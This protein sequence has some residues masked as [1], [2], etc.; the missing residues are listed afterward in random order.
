MYVSI[1]LETTGLKKTCQILEIGAVSSDLLSTFHCYVD[2]GTVKGEPYA[3]SIHS[4]ILRRIATKE[5]GYVYLKPEEVV[6]AFREWL[7]DCKIGEPIT[8]AGKNFAAFDLP[9]LRQLP[10][11]PDKLIRHRIIDPG[12]LY[13]CPRIDG[14]RLPCT[15]ACMERAGMVGEVAHTAVADAQVVIQLIEYWR[16]NPVIL[17]PLR[18]PGLLKN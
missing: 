18:K 3:L 11:W 8:A 7:Y 5:E 4:T 12:N 10:G 17:N 2:N 16:Q 14:E 6:D 15:E 9:F 13:W 1:D